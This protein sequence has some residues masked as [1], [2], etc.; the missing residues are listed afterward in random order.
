M[1][2]PTSYRNSTFAPNSPDVNQDGS[3]DGDSTS[4]WQTNNTT[5]NK[6]GVTHFIR[7]KLNFSD[8]TLWKQFSA[9]RLELISLMKLSEKKASE[10]DEEI[11]KCARLLLI[12]FQ[13]PE[14][15]LLDFDKLVRCAI[16]SVRRNKKR[17]WKKVA[18]V[19]PSSN[20]KPQKFVIF[21]PSDGQHVQKGSFRASEPPRLSSK[22]FLSQITKLNSSS[23]NEGETQSYSKLQELPSTSKLAINSLITPGRTNN[24]HSSTK[25][26]PVKSNSISNYKLESIMARNPEQ[27]DFRVNL[28]SISSLPFGGHNPE[29]NTLELESLS[30]LLHFIKKSKSCFQFTKTFHETVEEDFYNPGSSQST[31]NTENIEVVGAAA[32]SCCLAYTLQKYFSNS[33]PSSLSYLRIK[34]SS[35]SVLSR[36]LKNLDDSSLDVI[37]LGEYT[38]AQLLKKL[39]GCLLKDFGFDDILQ[40]LSNVFKSIVIKDYPLICKPIPKKSSILHAEEKRE[41]IV[42]HLRYKSKF[43]KFNYIHDTSSAPTIIEILDNAKTGFNIVDN[44][45]YLRLRNYKEPSEL[46]HNDLQLELFFQRQTEA[47][48]DIDIEVFASDNKE[49]TSELNQSKDGN[50]AKIFPPLDVDSNKAHHLVKKDSL[51]S[52]KDYHDIKKTQE[53]KTHKKQ[54]IMV[55]Q[56][57]L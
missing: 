2:L 33:S 49:L 44:N 34:L 56:P 6:V 7:K 16:Q 23:E 52:F 42:V 53:E 11:T 27:S 32:I 57:L 31:Y 13:Y 30:K 37:M 28:P 21:Q 3:K 24:S 9:R 22:D 18:D 41:D 17:S 15:N 20:P 50:T 40:P 36:I 46:F 43:L 4:S 10:Q 55:F 38:A 19:Q 25:D 8:E 5:S 54:K 47:G 12:E 26:L 14:E 39:I 29:T 35:D 48:K 51:H 1:P 45:K